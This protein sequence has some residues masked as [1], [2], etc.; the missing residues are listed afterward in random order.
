MVANFPIDRPALL[1]INRKS[2]TMGGGIIILAKKGPLFVGSLFGGCLFFWVF[3][4]PARTKKIGKR[5]APEKKMKGTNGPD[6]LLR[7]NNVADSTVIA[8][9]MPP[10]RYGARHIAR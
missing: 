2:A 1:E 8:T 6:P 10:G 5:G 7:C 3:A 4:F 9:T